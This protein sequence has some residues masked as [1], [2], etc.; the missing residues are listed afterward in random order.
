MFTFIFTALDN[1]FCTNFSVTSYFKWSEAIAI[2][3]T[4]TKFYI[5]ILLISFVLALLTG[6]FY[7]FKPSVWVFCVGLSVYVSYTS[8]AFAFMTGIISKNYVKPS[9][10]EVVQEVQESND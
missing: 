2:I 3:K 6:I 10:I 1:I 8:V 9:E 7:L 4:N 5:S